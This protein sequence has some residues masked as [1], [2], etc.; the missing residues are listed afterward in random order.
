MID[1]HREIAVQVAMSNLNWPQ[2]GGADSR[3]RRKHWVNLRV[4]GE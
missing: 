2:R 4:K 1:E 3:D